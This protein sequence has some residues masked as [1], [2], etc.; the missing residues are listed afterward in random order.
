MGTPV[1]SRFRA[2]GIRSRP[3]DEQVAH[4]RG[5][6]KHVSNGS[7]LVGDYTNPILKPQAAE[8]V[9]KRG[10]ISL[11]GAAPSPTNQ[12]R[13]G[14]VPYVFWNFGIEI[15]QQPD[16]ITIVYFHD[17]EVRH[18]RLNAHHPA[19]VTPSWYGNSVE[20]G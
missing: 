6:A 7:R 3:G 18:I 15:L 20:I 4:E 14:G 12:C 5:I 10:E 8:V 13:P 9:K 16:Q 1:P 2:A 11:T 17:H 19:H